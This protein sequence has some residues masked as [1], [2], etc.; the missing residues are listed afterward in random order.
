[1]VGIYAKDPGLAG[2]AAQTIV[3]INGIGAPES[4]LPAPVPDTGFG[5]TPLPSQ[6]PSPVRA[7]R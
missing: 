6:I 5:S 4:T 7:L 1:M 3:Q 2:A